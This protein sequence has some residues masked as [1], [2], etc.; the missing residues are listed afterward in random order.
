VVIVPEL[1]TIAGL[2]KASAVPRPEASTKTRLAAPILLIALGT[3][4]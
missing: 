2:A 4:K 3:F 1:A